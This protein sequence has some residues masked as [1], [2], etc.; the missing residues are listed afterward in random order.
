[1]TY[2]DRTGARS[3]RART[4]A[5]LG[6]LLVATLLAPACGD[7]GDENGDGGGTSGGGA[8]GS[9]GANSS[10]GTISVGGS[11]NQGGDGSGL[12]G[13]GGGCGESPFESEP[14]PVNIMLV[15]DK[16]GSMDAEIEAGT[17]RWEAMRDALN[18]AVDG[19]PES[20]SYGLYLYPSD[21]S[22]GVGGDVDVEVGPA[23]DVA[24]SIGDA[25]GDVTPE[26]STPTAKALQEVLTYFTDGA[27]AD[28]E[29]DKYVLLATDGGP[30][31]SSSIESCSA[32]NCTL[33]IEEEF[34]PG[35]YP[36]CS[37]T[38]CCA[39]GA[40]DQ[41]LDGGDTG[42]AIDDLAAAGIKT[43]VVGIPGTEAYTTL[44]DTLAEKGGAPNPDAP[45]SYFAVD[46]ADGLADTLG[47]ITQGF[48]TTCEF[49]LQ[50]D[51]PDPDKINVTVDGEVIPF[52]D[53]GEEGWTWDTSTDPDT[54]VLVGEAC[55]QVKEQGAQSVNVTFGCPTIVI[56]R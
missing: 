22:C 9:G 33:N 10:G 13:D 18:A 6:T 4:L 19:S 28:L 37:S 14:V 11:L 44:L 55:D 7:D 5:S 42:S 27:G 52:D 54:V 51:P 53:M 40:S 56:P 2:S 38:N 49:Q 3:P 41:C 24:S 8:N 32:T 17:S 35:T 20:I 43:I 25:L 15:I 23:A 26:G 12:G 46:D 47:R 39:G 45:P 31:C 48:I 50:S 21:A 34:N 1:M 16:S 29:G 30:N 36:A